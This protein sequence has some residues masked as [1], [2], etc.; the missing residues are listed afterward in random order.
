MKLSI[1]TVCYNEKNIERTLKNITSQTF[2]DFEWIV[3]DGKSDKK[4]LDI[5]KK[6]K[7]RINIL[8]SE[9]DN[10]I[11]DAMNKGIKFATG[12]YISFMNAGDSFYSLNTLELV[13]KNK[14]YSQD[15]LYG[16]VQIITDKKSFIEYNPSKITK[17]FIAF[18]GLN[19]QATFIKKSLFEKFGLYNTD[20]KIAFDYEKFLVFYNN[21]CSFKYLDLIVANFYRNGISSNKSKT[22]KERNTVRNKI[23]S[24]N[25]INNLKKECMTISFCNI[26]IL[27]IKTLFPK[28]YIKLFGVITILKL[29]RNKIYLLGLNFLPIFKM[30]G[31]INE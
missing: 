13:F 1:I 9:K 16:N 5:I 27:K 15:I 7:K 10:G 22:D 24:K 21:N 17:K 18:S 25:E 28:T 12:E 11:H 30:K 6:Y 31:K 4:T 26:P 29:K 2:Q 23:F 19:H 20:Y 8:V 14:N 3:I